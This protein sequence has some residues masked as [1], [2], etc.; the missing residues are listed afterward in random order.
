MFIEHIWIKQDAGRTK[1]KIQTIVTDAD[2]R[3]HIQ[4]TVNN[5]SWSNKKKKNKRKQINEQPEQ[6]ATTVVTDSIIFFSFIVALTLKLLISYIHVTLYVYTLTY[7]YMHIY[8]ICNTLQCNNLCSMQ[9][10]TVFDD[11]ISHLSKRFV[12]K[13]KKRN[14]NEKIYY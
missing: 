12:Y 8:F 10:Q 6:T 5:K 2:T 3:M 9:P 4:I 1:P 14:K 11:K 13:K 7:I